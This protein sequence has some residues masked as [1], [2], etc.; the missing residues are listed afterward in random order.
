MTRTAHRPDSEVSG[1]ERA[2]WEA[3]RERLSDLEGKAYEEAEL[4]SWEELQRTL[5]EIAEQ[6]NAAV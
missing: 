5:R 2:A 3:Y 4:I 6:E 1:A